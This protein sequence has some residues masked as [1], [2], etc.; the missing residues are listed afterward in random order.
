MTPD[1]V[2]VS[3]AVG[4]AAGFLARLAWRKLADRRKG[5]A[6]GCACSAKVARK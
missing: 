6:G 2:L 5:C 4:L 1:A 3:A